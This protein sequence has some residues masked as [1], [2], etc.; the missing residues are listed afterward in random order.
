MSARIS[1][2]AVATGTGGFSIRETLIQDPTG[3]EVLVRMRAA[4]ICHTDWDSQS[5]GKPLVM[6]H[7]GAGIVEAV[8]PDVKTCRPGDAVILN[9]AVPCYDCFQCRLGNESLC[10]VNSAVT[11]GN[12]VS[13][14]HSTLQSTTLD[15]VP[16]ER[17][18]SLGT[19][20]HF[21]LVRESACV[22]MDRP[23]P[24]PSA[25]IVGCGVMT[26]YGSVMHAAQVA[27][28]SSAVVLGAGGVG[29]NVIQALRLAGASMIIVVDVQE[30]RLKTAVR[31]GATHMLLA[32]RGDKGLL[33]VSGKVREMTTRGADYAFECTAIPELGVAPLAMVRNGGMAVQVSGVE[34]EIAVDMSLFEWDKVY[35]NPLYGKSRPKRDFPELQSLYHSGKLMLDELVTRTYRLEDLSLAFADLLAGR[36]AKG[37]IIFDS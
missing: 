6:G 35:I 37:V 16:V 10:E 15:G 26:G 20:S 36:N 17:S 34:K 8:G 5:W 3:D 19:M 21:A 23:I 18:F 22:V 32:D 31:F 24:F 11:A 4:G 25:A 13:G 33:H 7:E 30:D 27:A 9:W 1:P 28:G 29:L 2:A 14:G 12:K